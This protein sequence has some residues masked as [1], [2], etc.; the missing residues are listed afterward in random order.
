MFRFALVLVTVSASASLAVAPSG[1]LQPSRRA[2]V[3]LL[4]ASPPPSPPAANGGRRDDDDKEGAG[5]AFLLA[6]LARLLQRATSPTRRYIAV[7]LPAL[8]FLWRPFRR[9]F[10]TQLLVVPLV[11]RL[12]LFELQR[13]ESDAARLSARDA[14]D[15]RLAV[16]FAAFIGEMRGAF[17]KVAQVPYPSADTTCAWCVCACIDL[18]ARCCCR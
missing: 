17:I 11:A 13:F 18:R 7:T 4:A 15:E 16:R 12:K 14:L 2:A 8:F 3:S 6:A 1:R 5:S 10:K 9:A